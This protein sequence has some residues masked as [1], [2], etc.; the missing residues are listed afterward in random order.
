MTFEIGFLFALIALMLYLFL[1]EKLPVDL[2]AFLG[3]SILILG[4]YVT[5]AEA[6]SATDSGRILAL[7]GGI[8]TG[9]VAMSQEIAGLVE[10]STN[11]GVCQSDGGEIRIVCCSRSSL[12][13]A[14]DD[15]LASLAAIG[16]LA[17]AEVGQEGGYP[18]WQPNLDSPVLA[19]TKAAYVSQFGTE[20][21][22]E[23]I[24]AGLEC[25]LIG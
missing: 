23:A 16:R 13:P 9:V 3:L 22:V 4:N 8:P 14:L 17:G 11:L 2:T 12:A 24:H 20:P 15:V 10:T 19:A 6:F 21:K 1:T 18:G 25:G 5:P 7:L